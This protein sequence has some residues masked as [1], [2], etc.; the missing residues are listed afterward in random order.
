VRAPHRAAP[1]ALAACL[2]L[3]AGCA[4]HRPPAAAPAAGAWPQAYTDAIADALDPEPSEIA[5]DLVAIVRSNPMLTWRAFP[6][7]DR[8][9]MVSLVGDTSFYPS[10]PGSPYNTG[11][12]D[13]WVTAVPEM[14]NACTQPGFARG[15]LAM[16]LRQAIG[17]TP[18][19]TVTAF[20]EF[21]VLPS[22]LFRPAADNEIT[23]TTAGLVMPETTE[24]WY[25][26]W[27]NR[28]RASQYFQ[29]ADPAHNAY[30]WTQLGYT[31]DWGSE[32]HEG[33]SE[34]VI[35]QQSNVMVGKISDYRTYCR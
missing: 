16:R 17:L 27:F 18:D 13:I 33:Q 11:S 25:R 23:D 8:V 32:R 28:L 31:Y 4:G 5:T 10:A 26:E 1:L 7:G 22:Q 6:D 20:V 35:R 9:L 14:K 34:F 3:S 19:D 24:P 12:H 2:A 30:P 21:W 29:S 15:D